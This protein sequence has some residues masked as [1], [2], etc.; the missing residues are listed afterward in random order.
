MS[1]ETK[2]K[3]GEKFIVHNIIFKF[4]TDTHNLFENDTHCQ[5]LAS[6]E[7][8]GLIHVFNYATKLGLH[9][10]MMTVL[11]YKGFRLTAMSRL[12]IKGNET[13]VYGS[14]DAGKTILLDRKFNEKLKIICEGLGLKS[15]KI[16]PMSLRHSNDA[17][18]QAVTMH[19]PVDLEGHKGYDGR[20]YLLDFSR[21]F[22][23][24]LPDKNVKGSYLFRLLRPG[25]NI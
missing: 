6:H 20:Y 16:I 5:K 2:N 9:V 14:R 25:I 1:H 21:I 15:H 19:T 12:P 22:P 18:S 23:P 24:E 8:K 7:L 3:G 10:P 11:D 13:L 4:C 17:I